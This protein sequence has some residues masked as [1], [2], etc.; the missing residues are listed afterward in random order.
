MEERLQK[1]ISHA[2]LASRRAAE[3]MILAGR[4]QVNGQTVT[5]LGG[6]YDLS[7]DTIKVDGKLLKT[8]EEHVYF[9]LNKPKG[10]LSTAHDERGRRTVLDLLP[11]VRERIYPIGRLD[12][13]TEGLLLLTNDG[14][15]MNGLLHPRYEVE[16][17]YVARLEAEPAE[18]E[19][20]KLRAG[21]ELDDGL[22]APAKVRL[23]DSNRRRVYVEITIHEGRNRQ[24]RRMF[25]ALGYDVKALKRIEFAG[26]NL[27]G[28]ARGKYRPL[29]ETEIAE[30]YQKAG[31]NQ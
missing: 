29:T 24:V 26:L 30:L 20:D 12:A 25:Q 15:L 2:G 7:R 19:L 18:K 23:L 21:I 22:T 16:K 27:S 11:E 8:A 6:K 9:L 4:V 10:Y 31:L 3:E 28:T 5:E 17:T 1:I 13:N 14:N